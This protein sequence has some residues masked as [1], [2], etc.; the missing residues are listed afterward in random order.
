MNILKSTITS[1]A[2]ILAQSITALADMQPVA[3]LQI[4]EYEAGPNWN[5]NASP[6]EQDLGGHFEM[7]GQQFAEGA[8]LAFGPTIDDMHGH[9]LYRLDNVQDAQKIVMHDQGITSGVLQKVKITNWHLLMENLDQDIGSDQMFFLRYS[10]GNAWVAGKPLSEQ[11]ISSHAQ[12]V[13]DLYGRGKLLAGGPLSETEGL[14]LIAA[15]DM[16]TAQKFVQDDPAVR[17]GLF[18]VNVQTWAVMQRQGL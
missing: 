16:E 15:T 10:P 6:Q 12:H 8:L 4:I 14:Y 1:V 3:S 2:L 13:G 11:D 17:N 18:N 5:M 9:Y 7:V